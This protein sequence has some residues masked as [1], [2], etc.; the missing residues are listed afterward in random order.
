LNSQIQKYSSLV[1]KNWG[2]TFTACCPNP[3]LYVIYFKLLSFILID[4]IALVVYTHG[5][6][7][8][9]GVVA[10]MG[11]QSDYQHKL[12][13]TGFNLDKGRMGVKPTQ[14]TN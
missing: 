13:V 11:Q 4:T 2:Q 8:R 14:F 12:F 1:I 9:K 5:I 6:I 10:M 7:T 3:F